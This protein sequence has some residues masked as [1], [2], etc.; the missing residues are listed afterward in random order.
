MGTSPVPFLVMELL[1]EKVLLHRRI[2]RGPVDVAALVDTGLALAD[3]LA[4]AHARNIVH[5]DIK[6]ANLFV[7]AEGSLKVLDFGV[8][9]IRSA[10]A[11][12]VT[13]ARELE[14]TRPG[15]AV[16]TVAYMSP[17]QALGRDVDGRS[18][19]YSLGVVLYE[20]ATGVP[21]FV[22]STDAELFDRIL[23]VA[24]RPL[25]ELRPDLPPAL[26]RAVTKALTKDVAVRYQT[27]DELRADLLADAHARASTGR[28]SDGA[29]LLGTPLRTRR[30]SGRTPSWPEPPIC[31]SRRAQR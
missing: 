11:E 23:N 30:Y 15:V 27:A 9:K 13:R 26:A 19:I 24:P 1:D 10:S 4:A 3:A 21:P 20:M 22:G 29:I 6:P 14:L 28:R 2:A 7:T 5:R 18:D 31:D 25:E 17:E 8:A 16:G 12:A